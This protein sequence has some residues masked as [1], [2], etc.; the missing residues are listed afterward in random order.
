VKTFALLALGALA[1]GCDPPPP[2]A[3][4][5]A[6]RTALDEIV[7][8]G[9]AADADGGAPSPATPNTDVVLRGHLLPRAR[10]CWDAALT[11]DPTPVGKLVLSL[12]IAP[13]GDV[14]DVHVVQSMGISEKAN[15]C[16]MHIARG[17]VF[18]AMGSTGT[19]I[20]VPMSFAMSTGRDDDNAVRAMRT[21]MQTL[22]GCYATALAKGTAEGLAT[23]YV[24]TDDAGAVRA[25]SA[26][27]TDGL[28]IP[29][30]ECVANAI[31]SAKLPPQAGLEV[32]IRFVT[33]R[34]QRNVE[35]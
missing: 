10:D 31:K 9:L 4:A 34:A 29:L 1:L 23:Y 35:P 33:A 19:S 2:A 27:P 7:I 11:G 22:R 24:D 18:N 15:A 17:A 28:P 12:T 6:Q 30:L 21:V 3:P 25:L 5:P 20:T 13:S 8:L 26:D 16:I 32:P 14:K